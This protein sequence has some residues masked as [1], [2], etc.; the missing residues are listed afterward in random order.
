[1]KAILKTSYYTS[2]KLLRESEEQ[3]LRPERDRRPASGRESSDWQS[4][5]RVVA[6][7]RE[8]D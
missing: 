6:D 4:G 5:E 7:E 2:Y 8:R 1:V 3:R